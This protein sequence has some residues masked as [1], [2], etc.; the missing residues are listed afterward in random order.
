MHGFYRRGAGGDTIKVE[1]LERRQRAAVERGDEGGTAG[2]GD[3]AVAKVEPLE[4]LQPSS[5]RRR[6]AYRRRLEG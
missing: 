6:R 4:L 1:P 2:V 3:P 5:R